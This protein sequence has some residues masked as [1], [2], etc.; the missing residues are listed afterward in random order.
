MLYLHS[1]ETVC[2]FLTHFPAGFNM[3]FTK[4]GQLLVAQGCL[5]TLGL[6]YRV[7]TLTKRK[8]MHG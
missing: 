6:R 7:K 2:Q 4:W 5:N 8:I 3:V 1:A